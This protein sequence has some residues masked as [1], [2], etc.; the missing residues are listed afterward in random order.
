[1]KKTLL[2]ISLTIL[3]ITSIKS[4]EKIQLGIKGGI[5]FTNITSN[6]LYNKEYK[7]GFHVGA[8]VEIPLG[9]KFSLQ[10]EI[11]YSTQGAEGKVPML[12]DPFPGA[13]TP[14]PVFGEFKLDYIQIPVLAKIYL[15]KNFSL[16]IGP[17]FNFLIKD[18]EIITSENN[19][20]TYSG[21]G[22]NFEFSGIIGT[23]YKF[24]GGFFG[25]AR[26]VQGMSEATDSA[27][28][29]ICFQIGIGYFF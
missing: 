26:Y 6:D 24:E 14:P 15:I 25:S 27:A 1:M 29:N 16:D 19:S 2:I 13:P 9:N 8:L 17:S 28:K 20:F 23:S 7:T 12:Y 21:F 4:Q 3:T 11:L 22:N 5:N 10:P 18:K